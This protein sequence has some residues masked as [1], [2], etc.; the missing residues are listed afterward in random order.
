MTVL[1]KIDHSSPAPFPAM[2]GIVISPA[3][4][5]LMPLLIKIGSTHKPWLT[6]IGV[7][8]PTTMLVH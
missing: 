2:G 8:R 6:V 3:L 4:V 1:P 5:L 7:F